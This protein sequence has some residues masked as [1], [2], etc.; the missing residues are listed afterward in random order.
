M[1][2]KTI[3]EQLK[4]EI[5]KL[6]NRFETNE[7]PEDRRDREFFNFVKEETTP[8]HSLVQE[9]EKQASLFVKNKQVSVHPQQVASTSDNLQILLLNSYYI[10]TP[11]KRY[12][13]M[14]HSIHYVLD[15][16]LSDI[17]KSDVN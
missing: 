9:W 6:K 12:M 1:E 15:Q 16:L 5:T 11:R 14:Y 7:K 8:I 10:D 2:L 3:T 13:E 17:E 4:Q